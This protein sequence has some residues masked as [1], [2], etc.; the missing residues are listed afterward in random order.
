MTVEIGE[1]ERAALTAVYRRLLD[2]E[3]AA[4][5]LEWSVDVSVARAKMVGMD[6]ALG[7]LG[8]AFEVAPGHVTVELTEV[9]HG[10]DE[11]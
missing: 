9:A 3:W 6:T 5:S 11:A 1:D 4:R 7:I 8:L 10:G 2:D